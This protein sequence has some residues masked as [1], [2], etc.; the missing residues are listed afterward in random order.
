MVVIMMIA[1]DAARA[2]ASGIPEANACPLTWATR[3]GMPTPRGYLAA[4]AL[5]DGRILAIGG[6]TFS[7]PTAAVEAYSPQTNAWQSVA[8]LSTGR[9]SLAAVTV[10]GT[11]YALGGYTTG[12]TDLVE[13]YDGVANVWSGRASM[14]T[15]RGSLAA[16]VS[17]GK[18]YAIGGRDNNGQAVAVV[19]EYDSAT[20]LW[21]DRAPMPTARWGLAAATAPNGRIYAL[22]G[23]TAGF[24]RSTVEE[25]DPQTNSWRTVQPMPTAREG[26]AAVAGADGRIYIFGG[27]EL[28]PGNEWSWVV[29]TYDPTTDT[30]QPCTSLGLNRGYLAGVRGT[31]STFYALGGARGN[32]QEYLSAV[33]TALFPLPVKAYLPLILK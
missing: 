24:P 32:G 21:R 3:A 12:V 22:G 33:E 9:N 20:N 8:G 26:A 28:P 5:P 31:G 14:P 17:G 10:G 29:E 18:I 2:A 13:A 11:I 30:W 4:A 7:G 16:A 19:E 25:Y 15:A 23:A 27:H 1:T 6:W